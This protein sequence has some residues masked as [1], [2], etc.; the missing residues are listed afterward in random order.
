MSPI[1]ALHPPI[2]MEN[3]F[4][5]GTYSQ[6]A[7]AIFEIAKESG[8]SVEVTPALL[9]NHGDSMDYINPSLYLFLNSQGE[10]RALSQLRQR[11]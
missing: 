11:G 5:S 2:N 4:N 6:Y 7:F 3:V 10:L 9:N 8:I 1:R